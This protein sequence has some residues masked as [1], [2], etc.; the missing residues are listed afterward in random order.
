MVVLTLVGEFCFTVSMLET[1]KLLHL[2]IPEI[3]KY[4][5]KMGGTYCMICTI[6]WFI[7]TQKK[8]HG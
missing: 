5:I 6:S 3:E 2:L 7:D 1:R 8:A 4:E